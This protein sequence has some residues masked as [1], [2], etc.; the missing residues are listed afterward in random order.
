[1][2]EREEPSFL[3]KVF[4][5]ICLCLFFAACAG[6]P[7]KNYVY[8]PTANSADELQNL[9]TEMRRTEAEQIAVFAPVSYSRASKSWEKAQALQSKGSS[10]AEVLEELGTARSYFE[11]ARG[12]ADR[13]IQ[14]LPEVADAREKALVA[15]AARY[16]R[17]D[18]EDAD[19]DLMKITKGFE[20]KTPD[21]SLKDRARLQ[22]EFSN[23]EL[24]SIK[25]SR[26]GDTV[27]NIEAAERMGAAK[28]APRTLASAQHMLQTAE[29]TINAD[30][31]NDAVVSS[32]QDDAFRESLKLLR[33]N[34]LSKQAGGRG[35]EAMALDIFNRDQ[36]ISALNSRVNTQET[37]LSEAQKS[38]MAAQRELA[39]R[40][41]IDE[42]I[43]SIRE[44]F[45]PEEAEV[46][47]QGENLIIRLKAVSFSSGKTAV[48][49]SAMPVLGKVRD[50]IH[51]A[52]AKKVVVEGHSDSVG[53]PE[54]NE[55]ISQTRAASVARALEEQGVM[56]TTGSSTEE[57]SEAMIEARG[58]GAR[59][60]IA[61][62][63]TKVGR[64]QNRRVDVVITPAAMEAA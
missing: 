26:L 33:V 9:K 25:A 14:S 57:A 55:K 15:G 63:A 20:G 52:N 48:P 11:Q 3:M 32:A 8:A 61:T 41:Q 2:S 13:S 40:Q 31:H 35:N 42:M 43:S 34:E 64:A 60:P 16:H 44:Q 29:L 19:E 62:N 4:F 54:I 6:K 28:Y 51:M 45:S 59:H 36:Q 37:E 38:A 10:N 58:Y 22:N 49:A 27:S 30:R 18:L 23:L 39:S 24:R 7:E 56:K 1:M 5:V 53:K 47:R 17:P 50:A 12:V 46:L 21:V